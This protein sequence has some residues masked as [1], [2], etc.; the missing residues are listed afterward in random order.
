MRDDIITLDFETYW[1]KDY[2]LRK[3]ATSEYIR[4][5]RFKAQCVGIKIGANNVVWVPD[6][7]VEEALRSIDWASYALLAHHTQFDGFILT[8][9]YG[10]IPAYYLCTLSMGRGLHSIGVGASLDALARFYNLGNKIPDVL[11]R[12]KG[13]L[14]WPPE[15][16]QD[17]G[18]YC[19]MDTKLCSDLFLKMLPSFATSEL[20]LID[21]TCRMFCEPVLQV[22]IPTAKRAL[23]LE[24]DSKRIKIAKAETD[25]ANLSSNLKFAALLKSLGVEIPMKISPTTKK[26]A[27]A[28]AKG[29]AGFQE[30]MIHEDEAVRAIVEARIA[31]KSTIGSTRAQRL[32]DE[33]ANGRTLP[34]YLK[35]YGAH[36]GRWSGGNRMNLQNLPRAYPDDPNSGLLRKSIIAPE[37]YVI[38]VSDLAQIEAR[39]LAWLAKDTALLDQ[40]R[41]EQ[42]AYKIM[43]ASIY[44]K[45]V[46]EI[47]KTERFVGKTAILGLGYQMGWRRFLLTVTLGLMGPK[48][49]M[50]AETAQ[51]VVSTYRQNRIAIV[52]FWDVCT[53][54]LNHMLYDMDMEVGPL[55]VDGKNNRIYMPNNMYLEYP[56][57]SQSN[58]GFV[59]FDYENAD[60]MARGGSPNMKKARKIYGGLLTENVTQALARIVIGDQLLQIAKRYKVASTTHDEIIAVAPVDEADFALAYML[61]AMRIPPEWAPDLP[62]D[63][64]GGWAREYSK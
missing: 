42:D 14:D 64:E 45:T 9:R 26:P 49:D 61:S 43:A 23:K 55:R 48:M 15:L 46:E 35:Y 63:A 30:L 37:G 54:M 16:M 50:K 34:V 53:D 29:D 5:D 28:F 31:V 21:E 40:F 8:E 17:A 57:L 51:L 33:G 39:M 12:T 36:T 3:L 19:A 60:I 27:Y 10:I 4:D 24:L 47:S 7:N 6:K 32:L 56:G 20:D 58:D 25:P 22:H 18:L 59:F 62:L 11:N 2:T 41:S 38:V 13:V 1:D 52:R 44:H